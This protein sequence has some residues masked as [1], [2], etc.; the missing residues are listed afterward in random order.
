MKELAE[1]KLDDGTTVY[2]EVD[3][4]SQAGRV[5][6][7]DS[8]LHGKAD[9]RFEEALSA[10]RPAAEKVVEAFREFNHPTEIGLEFSLK[11]SA[12]V[13]TFVFSGDS[14]ATFKVSLAWKHE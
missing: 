1:L 2:V 8:E 11:F 3:D 12:A 6:R 10:V 13:N 14:E 9:K 7:T 5:S 4:V